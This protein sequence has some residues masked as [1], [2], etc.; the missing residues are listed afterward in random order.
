M[1]DQIPELPTLLLLYEEGS[2]S[3]RQFGTS[4]MNADPDSEQWVPTG[5][6]IQSYAGQIFF[7]HQDQG[8]IENWFAEHNYVDTGDGAHYRKKVKKQKRRETNT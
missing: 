1:L 2:W 3:Q 8:I 7:R 5:L 4:T 6:H